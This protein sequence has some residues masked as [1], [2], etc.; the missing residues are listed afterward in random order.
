MKPALIIGLLFLALVNCTEK[1]KE[2]KGIAVTRDS[3]IQCNSDF[4]FD[5]IEHYKVSEMSKWENM[6]IAKTPV[7]NQVLELLY[8]YS[9]KSLLSPLTSTNLSEIG[10]TEWEIPKKN[11]GKICEIFNEQ[12]EYPDS[13]ACS[14]VFR[15]IIVFK[16]KGVVSGFA[17]CCFQCGHSMVLLKSD[18]TRNVDL[19][20]LKEFLN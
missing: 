19:I 17:K 20:K 2:K 14:P 13:T 1:V 16:N 7:E 3:I 9:P 4:Q 6:N 5:R 8:R 15:D 10:F 11:Y 12:Y 18:S